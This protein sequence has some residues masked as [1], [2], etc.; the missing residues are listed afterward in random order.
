MPQTDI[1]VVDDN[2]TNLD[3]LSGLLQD[4]QFHVRA[5]TS[6]RLALTVART[7][8]PALILL[9]INMPQMNGFE[10]CTQLKADPATCDIPVIFISALDETMDKVRAFEV[11][12]VDYVTKP[13]QIE[14][15]LAR[16]NSQLRIARLQHELI[17]K[18]AA[19]TQANA[20]LS[21]SR[22]ELAEANIQLREMAEIKANF[23]A[24]LV[25]DLKSPLSVVKATLDFLSIDGDVVA[26]PYGALVHASVKTI[27][28]ILAMIGEL[29]EVFRTDSK[30][31]HLRRESVKFTEFLKEFLENTR[32][33]AQSENLVL[34]TAISPNL[35]DMAIDVGKLERALSNLLSNAIKFTPAGGTI[36]V[37]ASEV[38]HM[39]SGVGQTA[40]LIRISDTGEGIEPDVLPIIFDPYRQGQSGKGRLGVGLGL[41]IVKRIIEAHNGTIS[42]TSQ[43]GKGTTFTIL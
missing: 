33:A 9:D 32:I 4:H 3:L 26:G 38:M 20:D 11:G 19:L 7:F 6:G 35:P 43:L 31:I 5:A 37:E 24:M 15:V 34:E 39:Q 18:N 36:S 14:E 27:S 21:A 29:L 22:Q 25:H 23:T 41:A 2:P 10:V 16:V 40:V 30:E 28:K 1:L 13:F 42:A 17:E 8:K 12:G